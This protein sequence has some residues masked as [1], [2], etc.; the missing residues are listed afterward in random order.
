MCL[1]CKNQILE[2]VDEL[3]QA[4][5]ADKRGLVA[6][7]LL[8]ALRGAAGGGEVAAPAGATAE[9]VLD[10]VPTGTTMYNADGAGAEN[11]AAGWRWQFPHLAISASMNAIRTIMT[12]PN[13]MQQAPAKLDAESR[14]L[15][16]LLNWIHPASNALFYNACI[17][18]A[19]DAPEQ[20]RLLG[21]LLRIKDPEAFA[22]AVLA[23]HVVVF[24][25]GLR[26]YQDLPEFLQTTDVFEAIVRDSGAMIVSLRGGGPAW[27]RRQMGKWKTDN[28]MQLFRTPPDAMQRPRNLLCWHCSGP[29]LQEASRYVCGGCKA[30]IYCS[31]TCQRH[32]WRFCHKKICK[33]MKQQRKFAKESLVMVANAYIKW[34]NGLEEWR[35]MAFGQPH[36]EAVLA[37]LDGL[38]QPTTTATGDEGA[39]AQVKVKKLEKNS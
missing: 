22:A 26:G 38:Q 2:S 35:P 32:D 36:F 15:L 12:N 30:G 34:K 11:A 10:T 13:M 1:I 8:E 9:A 21:A 33:H 4:V 28:L 24:R 39:G 5:G 27:R 17:G 31:S 25:N 6:A 18:T 3:C 14:V 16:V 7:G 20:Q 29:T 23:A 37:V 19:P